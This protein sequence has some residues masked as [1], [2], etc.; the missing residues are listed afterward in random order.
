MLVLKKQQLK[1]TA[2][3]CFGQLSRQP[4]QWTELIIYSFTWRALLFGLMALFVL[5]S[6][7]LR[8][9]AASEG[10]GCFAASTEERVFGLIQYNIIGVK[11]R[12]NWRD[13]VRQEMQSY[14][15]SPPAYFYSSL[16][17][18]R[19][20]PFCIIILSFHSWHI[21]RPIVRA[22]KVR[23]SP[24]GVQFPGKLADRARLPPNIARRAR[25]L[26]CTRW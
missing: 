16:S 9:S 12:R 6:C 20:L 15:Y 7:S 21:P 14:H 25:T 2:N 4:I 1:S 26:Q 8:D 22:T 11:K 3:V 17:L 23:S 5:A 19:S 18:S 13:D 10:S 24:R